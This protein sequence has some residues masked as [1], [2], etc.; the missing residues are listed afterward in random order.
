MKYRIYLLFPAIVSILMSCAAPAEPIGEQEMLS[1]FYHHLIADERDE[2]AKYCD[3]ALRA[4]IESLTAEMTLE[5]DPFINAQDLSDDL[6]QGHF[7]LRKAQGQGWWLMRYET[8][9]GD[10]ASVELHLSKEASDYRIDDVRLP[11][12]VSVMELI[13]QRSMQTGLR[14]SIYV[15]EQTVNL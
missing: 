7:A 13:Q 6:R 12:G 9:P 5:A 14:D 2:A 10:S 1:S 8:V 15:E 4:S 11:S 3:D